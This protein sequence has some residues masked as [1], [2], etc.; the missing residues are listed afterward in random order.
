MMVENGERK[1][2][3]LFICVHNSGRS[4]MAEAFLKSLAGNR[5]EVE[6][7]G[8]EPTH[9]NPLVI[10][11]MREAGMDLSKNR[12][13]S[14][15]KLYQEGRLFDYVITVCDKTTEKQ[16]PLFPGVT[17]RLNWP[18]DNPEEFE[19]SHEEKLTRVRHLR[20]EIKARIETWLRDLQNDT[21][22]DN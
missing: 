16:C 8:L 17:R 2:R 22:E 13:E 18:F 12:T 1:R 5:F 11:A 21:P 20:D 3:V 15:F 7:A 9:V 10:E 4:Q 14:V 19:G 6:S